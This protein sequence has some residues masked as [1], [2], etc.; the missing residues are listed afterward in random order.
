MT[1]R[2]HGIEISFDA[3]GVGPL[4]GD[5]EAALFRIGQ[6]ALTNVVRHAEASRT[7]VRLRQEGD[8]ITLTV[9]DDG[10]GFDPASRSIRSRRLGLASMRERAAAEGGTLVVE[11]AL[12]EGTTVRAELPAVTNIIRLLLVDDH[13][14]VREGLRSFLGRRPGLE[15]VGEAGDVDSAVREAERTQ[16]D[17]VL[18]DLMLPGGGGVAATKRLQAL[19]P[20]PRVLVLTS[21][22]SDEQ[23]LGSG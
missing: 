19:D 9:S 17:L 7:D 4:D 12:G 5:R 16:P 6:E 2:L 22:V 21:F 11:S 10:V 23:A 20:A 18:L 13:P 15:V 3:D 8:R 1:G 14:V